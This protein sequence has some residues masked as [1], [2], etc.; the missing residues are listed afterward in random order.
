MLSLVDRNL[1]LCFVTFPTDQPA[2][3]PTSNAEDII[4]VDI[5]F[6]PLERSA[7]SVFICILKTKVVFAKDSLEVVEK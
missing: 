6:K 5:N 1:S 3:Q 4:S 2:N 7:D